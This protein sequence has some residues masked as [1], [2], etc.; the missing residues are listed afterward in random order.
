MPLLNLTLPSTS[1][2]ANTFKK[3]SWKGLYREA[4]IY[5]AALHL[6]TKPL[7]AWR[8]ALQKSSDN[9]NLYDL[10]KKGQRCLGSLH[11]ALKNENFHYRPGLIRRYNFN[12]KERNIFI[13]PWEER[14]V[15]FLLFKTLNQRL[16]S[17]FSKCTFA[18]RE[19]SGGVDSCQ[20]KISRLIKTNEKP[21]FL[22]KRDIY[23]YFDSVDQEILLHYLESCIEKNDYLYQLLYQRICFQY[24][25]N[26]ALHTS[27]KGIPFG[28][29]IACFF[30]NIFLTELDF[31]ISR[32][33]GIHYFRYADDF[34][35]ISSNLERIKNAE[36]FFKKGIKELKLKEK[37][38]HHFNYR[39]G[40][41]QEKVV[42]FIPVN[43]FRHLGLEFRSSG[44]TGLS[45]DKFR[46]IC[47]IFRYTFRRNRRKLERIKS[48]EEKIKKAIKLVHIALERGVRNVA[49]IDYYLK[50]V[51]DEKQLKLLD[52]WLAEKILFIAFNR[53]HKKGNFHKIGFKKLREWG[54]PSFLHR[55]RLIRHGHIESPFFIWKKN[56][57][58]R[59]GWNEDCQARET[60]GIGNSGFL[61]R[62]RS[63]SKKNLVR[64]RCCL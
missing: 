41:G 53:G 62:P 23:N 26:N 28:T 10:A 49:I 2:P 60:K 19:E 37:Q 46:K 42:G 52:R 21:L 34:L 9:K 27:R 4:E 55:H 15:D 48:I 16:K 1:S 11:N 50:H 14:I 13:F 58:F 33:S 29:S 6:Y 7:F 36:D 32:I 30:A 57:E 18:Y 54:L 3:L 12:G 20:W 43:K 44:I 47:N 5:K 25:E 35:I 59:G 38:G 63:S 8:K 51:M 31:L 22:L 61:S 64:E 17:L 45:R 56:Q 24:L 40:N 39:F